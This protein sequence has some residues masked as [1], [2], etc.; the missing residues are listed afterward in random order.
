MQAEIKTGW[1]TKLYNYEG[2]EIWLGVFDTEEEAKKKSDS[3]INSPDS[4][5]YYEYYH[6][7]KKYKYVEY[8]G[9]AFPL[10][11]D[12]KVDICSN[13]KIKKSKNL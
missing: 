8:E 3:L 9:M 10:S 11:K 4:E 13:N 7:I 1:F 5:Y 2:D 12:R 6:I